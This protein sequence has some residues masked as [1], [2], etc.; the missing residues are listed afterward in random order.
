MFPLLIKTRNKD[1]AIKIPENSIFYG[2]T[3]RNFSQNRRRKL[4]KNNIELLNSI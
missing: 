2:F 3:D 1:N 4:S